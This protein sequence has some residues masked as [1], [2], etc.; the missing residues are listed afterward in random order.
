MRWMVHGW[1]IAVLALV[2]CAPSTLREQ[3]STVEHPAYGVILAVRP[4]HPAQVRPAQMRSAGSEPIPAGNAEYIVRAE[5]GT[6]LA[7][8]LP[9]DPVLRPGVPVAIGRG[10]RVTLAAR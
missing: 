1:V 7:L 8:V 2:S 9:A 5:D 4:I 3:S 10:E 6:T